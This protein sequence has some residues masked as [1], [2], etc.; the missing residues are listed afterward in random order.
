MDHRAG[1]PQSS[2]A[3]RYPSRSAATPGGSVRIPAALCGVVGFKPTF[4]RI[5]R[6]GAISLSQSQDTIGII[7]RTVQ[8]VALALAVMAEHD[9]ADPASIKCRPI[10]PLAQVDANLHNTRIGIDS[11]YLREKSSPD[12]ATN[13][14]ASWELLESMGAQLVEVDLRPL[15]DYDRA[16]SLL[17]WCEAAAVHGDHFGNAA[18]DYPAAIRSRLH[19]AFVTSSADH[20]RALCAQGVSLA[21]FLNTVFDERDVL[22]TNT[23][24]DT[25]PTI[26]AATEDAAQTTSRLLRTTRP[27]SFLGL[28]AI[29]VPAGTDADGLPVGLQLAGRPFADQT[30]LT[31]AAAFQKCSTS[32]LP[33]PA[34]A[35][36]SNQ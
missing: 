15:R 6:R 17:T 12:I 8:D 26:V 22:A 20:V 23:T 18:N 5:S 4:G 30:V 31:V 35:L 13:I 3:V 7:A 27:F 11:A 1:R 36:E 33:I 2:Q 14:E 32:I 16:G 9:P 28:P 19:H 21:R 24:S 25:A 34:P 29:T 10:Q